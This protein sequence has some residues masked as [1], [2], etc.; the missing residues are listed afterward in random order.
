MSSSVYPVR[1]ITPSPSVGITSRG[2]S[3]GYAK[4]RAGRRDDF[5]LG[6]TKQINQI[7]EARGHLVQT[8]GIRLLDRSLPCLGELT[9]GPGDGGRCLAGASAP[10][11][12]YG[13]CNRP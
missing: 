8:L 4:V 1:M 11:D 12:H 13:H 6:L 9:Q 7:S 5:S 3:I 2:T 10:V